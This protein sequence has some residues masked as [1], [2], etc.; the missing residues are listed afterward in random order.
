M[1]TWGDLK[2]TINKTLKQTDGGSGRWDNTELLFRGN[3]IQS[4][5]AS[6]VFCLEATEIID[7]TKGT[8]EYTPTNNWL[9]ARVVRWQG[10]PLIKTTIEQIA[11]KIHVG[12]VPYHG[13]RDQDT[14]RY[15][16]VTA[17]KIG[18]VPAPLADAGGAIEV[19]EWIRATEFADT[20]TTCW[21]NL[22][23]MEPFTDITL[24]GVV[25]WCLGEV[26]ESKGE[27]SF[28]WQWFNRRIIALSQ[29]ISDRFGIVVHA[30]PG[31][32][33]MAGLKQT[34]VMG[35]PPQPSQPLTGGQ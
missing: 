6:E 31:K 20:T 28:W 10:I 8:N 22:K 24:F 19:L 21:N 2:T 26:G 4:A 11:H 27:I 16:Y 15:W 18:I 1:N 14:P 23:Y 17:G 29:M 13:V 12:G 25:A 35:Q 7:A 3:I 33:G 5:V 9:S 32:I 30:D 34:M